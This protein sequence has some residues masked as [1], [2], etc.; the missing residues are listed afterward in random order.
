MEHTSNY[1]IASLEAHAWL[2]HSSLLELTGRA[3]R[4]GA[5]NGKQVLDH[6]IAAEFAVVSHGT[7]TD[8]LFNYANPT[9]LKL[10][11]MDF[12]SFIQLPSRKSAEAPNREERK[13]LLDTVAKQ[14]Y[15][16]DYSGI[17]ISATGRRFR[18]EDATV[19]N[20]C[21]EDNIAVGQAALIKKWHYLDP[22]NSNIDVQQQQQ[23]Q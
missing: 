12:E 8:P 17:R 1:R 3:L 20:L 15:I 5:Y 16:K 23:Q 9:A 4:D 22:S 7:E 13:Q 18:I 21:D 11:E 6:L 19:W 10:F 2:L 14:G